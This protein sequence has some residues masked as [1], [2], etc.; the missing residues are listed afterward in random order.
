M[1]PPSKQFQVLRVFRSMMAETRVRYWTARSSPARAENVFVSRLNP[2][3]LDWGN[4]ATS[5][6]ITRRPQGLGF[7]PGLGPDT[8]SLLTNESDA[9]LLLLIDPDLHVVPKAKVSS[10]LNF[11]V[12]VQL[13]GAGCCTKAN[14]LVSCSLWICA[15]EIGTVSRRTKHSKIERQTIRPCMQHEQNFGVCL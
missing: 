9:T 13:I 12:Q 7:W 1:V 4:E 14:M 8:D 10:S 3:S 6:T 5:L 11:S 15:T 2:P